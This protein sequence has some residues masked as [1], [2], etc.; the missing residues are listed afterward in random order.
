MSTPSLTLY[1]YTATVEIVTDGDTL[2]VVLDLGF[3]IL[4]RVKVR[5]FGCNTAEP[6]TPAGDAATA[7]LRGLLPPGTKVGLRSKGVDKYGGRTNAQLFLK[8]ATG[9]YTRDLVALLVAEGWAVAWNGKGPKP[10]PVWPRVTTTP[11][12]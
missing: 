2:A 1:D 5:L 11:A 3:S 4:H 12:V 6:R 8:D 10:L 7:F 9:A